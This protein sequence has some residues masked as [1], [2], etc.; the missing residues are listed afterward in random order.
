M[1]KLPEVLSF[2][3]RLFLSRWTLPEHSYLH[4]CTIGHP[5]KT[6]LSPL[7][8]RKNRASGFR[9]PASF[10]TCEMHASKY[11]KQHGIF[12]TGGQMYRS[13][14]KYLSD[15]HVMFRS[16]RNCLKDGSTSPTSTAT[17]ILPV[18][19]PHQVFPFSSV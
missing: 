17:F 11:Q 4:Q 14:F 18:S 12:F 10:Y 13:F 16:E 19:H 8:H 3:P 7:K 6:A 1:K 15:L 2:K 5:V 9:L